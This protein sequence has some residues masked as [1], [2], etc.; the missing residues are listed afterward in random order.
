[1][2]SLNLPHGSKSNDLKSLEFSDLKSLDLPHGSKPN[3]LKSLDLSH[4]SKSNDLKWL[5]LPHG[6]KFNDLKSLN[7]VPWGIVNDFKSFQYYTFTN[8]NIGKYLISGLYYEAALLERNLLSTTA[9]PRLTWIPITWFPI[10]W[11][12]ILVK[13]NSYNVILLT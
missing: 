9:V 3:D 4:G 2:K 8:E 10:T 5:D 1:M 13:I 11:C 12:F 6:S 7:L